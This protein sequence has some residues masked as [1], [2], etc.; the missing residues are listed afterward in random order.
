MKTAK[1]TYSAPGTDEICVLES[2][3]IADSWYLLDAGLG[4][5]DVEITVGDTFTF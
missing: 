2:S 4:T 1:K 5:D 3:P